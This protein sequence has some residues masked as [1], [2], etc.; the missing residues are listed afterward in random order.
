MSSKQ[1]EEIFAQERLLRTRLWLVY[2]RVRWP[3]CAIAL[4]CG[5]LALLMLG[6]LLEAV[7]R[8]MSGLGRFPF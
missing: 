2:L 8:G 1:F 4:I 3:E 6:R 5:P 7:E